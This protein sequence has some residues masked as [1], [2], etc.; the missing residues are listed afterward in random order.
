MLKL[1][2]PFIELL[3]PFAPLFNAKTWKKIQIL[4]VGSILTPAKRTVTSALRVMGL[5]EDKNFAKYHHVLNRAVWSSLEVAQVLLSML[6]SY[7][8]EGDEPLVFGIEMG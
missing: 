1:P 2:Q 5:S 3:E 7:L 6:L 4:V 8:D